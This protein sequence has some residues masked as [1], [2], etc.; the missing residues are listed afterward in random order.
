MSLLT[1]LVVFA[2]GD[3]F[4]NALSSCSSYKESGSVNTGGLN[5]TSTKQILG[6]ENDRCVYKET[7]KYSDT[8]TVVTCKFRKQQ[9]AELTGVMNAY[10]TLQQY[11]DNKIDTNN[12]NELQDNPV[13]KVWSRYLQDSST[14][15][16][17]N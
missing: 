8:P 11:S 1:T 4:T 14:C 17:I 10:T 5:V 2:Q 6:W 12:L 13:V 15:S 7:V 9:I 3:K 16:V